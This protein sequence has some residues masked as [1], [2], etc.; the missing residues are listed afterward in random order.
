MR[1]LIFPENKDHW[2]ELR[3]PNI[4]STEMAAL[5]NCSPY[6]TKFELFHRKK[7]NISR[8]FKE[9]DRTEWGQFLEE[10]IASKFAK[11]NNWKLKKMDEYIFDDNL[12]IGS[13][14]DFNCIKNENKSLVEV[15]NVD[16]LIFQQGWIVEDDYIEAPPHIEVQI[17]TELFVS[18]YKH[19]YLCVLIG[20]NRGILLERTPNQ[21][22]FNAIIRE[23]ELFWKSIENNNPP[24]PSEVDSEFICS[25]YNNADGKTVD[26]TGNETI[27]ALAAYYKTCQKEESDAT[28]KK[29]AV[30]AKILPLIGEA[31]KVL[32]DGGHSISA[33][34][35]AE[36]EV[37][38]YTRKGYRRFSVNGKGEE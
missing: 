4:N 19:L 14:F 32:V 15:K 35:V 17:Q 18:E 2:L 25:L 31:S 3:K 6:L 33:G 9:N 36:T 11:D 30:K 8:D 23:A 13:S 7:S 26:M 28:A 5:F 24:E 37:A 20:G 27:A 22:I 29:K 12:G 38:A 16:S 1:Q 10:G 34:M 21:K